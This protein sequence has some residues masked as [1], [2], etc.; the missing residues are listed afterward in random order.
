MCVFWCGGWRGMYGI[1]DWGD[2][3]SNCCVM[4]MMCRF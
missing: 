4:L 3:L 1:Y 2:V